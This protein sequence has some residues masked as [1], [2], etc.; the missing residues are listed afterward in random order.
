V[1]DTRQILDAIDSV[2]ELF[3]VKHKA[4]NDMVEVVREDVKRHSK[5]IGQLF[6]H[7][8]DCT[9]EIAKIDKKVEPA[10]S[11]VRNSKQLSV[12][13]V[14]TGIGILGAAFW[15]TIAG[16]FRGGG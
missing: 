9:A 7:D 16:L 3:E 15:K 4:T 2:K 12:A 5:D 1:D 10:I 8:R 13:F 6:D 11:H 14:L